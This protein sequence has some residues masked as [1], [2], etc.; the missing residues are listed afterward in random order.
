MAKT[1]ASCQRARSTTVRSSNRSSS[2]A[3]LLA[4]RHVRSPPSRPPLRRRKRLKAGGSGPHICNAPTA[5]AHSPPIK[6]FRHGSLAVGSNQS[7]TPEPEAEKHRATQSSERPSGAC[8][9]LGRPRFQ[10]HKFTPL[11]AKAPTVTGEP[12]S[13]STGSREPVRVCGSAYNRRYISS[14]F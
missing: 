7:P 9:G 12:R 11:S 4:R 3:A 2:R 6:L 8:N 5:N 14:S 10:R 13:G 1:M